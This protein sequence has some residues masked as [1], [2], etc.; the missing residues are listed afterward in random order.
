M[1]VVTDSQPASTAPAKPARVWQIDVMRGVSM[2]LMMLL[3]VVAYYKDDPVAFII[4][5][6]SQLSVPVFIFCS[7][8]LFF[9]R[10]AANGVYGWKYY[11]KRFLRL[12]KPYLLFLPPYFLL[13]LYYEP[14]KLTQHYVLSSIFLTDGVYINWLPLLFLYLSLLSPPLH[15]LYRKRPSLLALWLV[16]VTSFTTFTF[17]TAWPTWWRWGMWIG[18]SLLL[19]YCWYVS[20]LILNH[21][22]RHMIIVA[23]LSS[24]ATA[25]LWTVR[26]YGGLRLEVTY[27]KYPPNIY[28]LSYCMMTIP[29]SWYAAHLS[30]FRTRYVMPVISY[31]SKHS[32]PLFFIHFFVIFF[33]LYVLPTSRLHW[34]LY[35]I[36][37]F[38]LALL[39]QRVISYLA[40]KP[41][42]RALK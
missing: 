35:S 14:A 19:P 3:H 8:Y 10:D 7:A 21:K 4:W 11:K 22:R 37:M 26:K 39:A 9:T 33:L 23:I 15:M 20:S 27:S 29:L 2:M 17:T 31:F 40:S 42:F 30:I 18:W 1:L 24:V 25:A 6:F 12:I 28:Y 36:L 41:M 13:V 38:S 34:S 16:F 32:Y 5:E